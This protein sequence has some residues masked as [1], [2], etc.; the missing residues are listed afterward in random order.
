MTVITLKNKNYQSTLTAPF[1]I[2]LGGM[3]PLATVTVGSGGSSTVEFTS[4]VGY[5][6][7]LQIRSI[8]R[9]NRS[10][11]SGDT[12]AIRFNSDTGNNYARHL[13]YGD[14]SAAGTDAVTSTSSIIFSRFSATSATTSIFGA[15]VVDILDYA[16]TNKYKTLRSLGAVELNGS[17][18]LY[19]ASGVWMN[20]N[21]ITSIQFISLTSSSFNQYSTFALYGIKRAG[22]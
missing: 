3:I 6:E 15:G 20:T 18:E 8:G 12:V 22:A 21:A 13:L 14:G 9:T 4:I 16:N 10:A 5:Y 11:N 1:D 19:L 2:D 17:G 7:H